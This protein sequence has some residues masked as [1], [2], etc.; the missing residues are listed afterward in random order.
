MARVVIALILVAVV[1]LIAR[2]IE[3]GRPDPPARDRYPIPAQL[4]RDDFPRP[5]APWLVV[6]FSS[7]SCDSC[8][9]MAARVAGLESPAV[10]TCEA[11]VHERRDLHTRYGVEGVPM[12]VVADAEG[13]VRKGFVGT[14][15]AH[16]LAAALPSN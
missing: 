14:V 13:V 5:D 4:D 15:S 8:A 7:T 2:R 11:D 3:V 16:D 10:A 12:V 1:V 9:E 6:L